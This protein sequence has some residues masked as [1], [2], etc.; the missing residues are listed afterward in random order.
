MTGQNTV[1][2][3][4]ISHSVQVENPPLAAYSAPT[5]P[6]PDIADATILPRLKRG[7]KRSVAVSKC[8]GK[9]RVRWH[10][11]GC[12]HRK[13]FGGKGSADA[14]AA[15]VR[16]DALSR[17]Q[18]LLGLTPQEQDQ[19]IL[20]HDEARRRG[21]S[22]SSLLT[23]L[24]SEEGKPSA[25]PSIDAVLKEMIA[26]KKVV[27]RDKEYLNSLE[28]IIGGFCKGRETLG[29]DQFTYKDVELWMGTKSLRYRT[30]LRSRISTL[31]RFAVKHGYRA[32]NPCDR[33]E[34]ITAAHVPPA[35]LTVG[36][37]ERCMKWFKTR[38]RAMAWFILS[39]F[40]GLR[41]EEASQTPWSAINFKEG[42]IAISPQTTKVRQRRIVYPKK[43]AMDWLKLA[44][45]RKAELPLTEK[46]LTVEQRELRAVLGW[47]KWKQDVTRHSAA[48]YWLADCRAAAHVADA[49]GT[50]E[51]ILQK[52][53]KALVTKS[54]ALKY[55]SI[56]P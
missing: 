15:K 41:P 18:K 1:S 42:W 16:G 27:K 45:R 11:S 51:K 13:F 32:D 28:Q 2:G 54:D 37:A 17:H 3:N 19:L 39:A 52:H 10:E 50:S 48:S 5:Q 20:V 46:Q 22:L 25:S 44:K 55:W 8:A 26:L 7:R 35:V 34:S 30:T 6:Q 21:V 43:M 56:R 14:F 31:F 24:A 47:E 4:G 29:I 12:V 49:L 53:Y 9:W 36:E 33:L 23:L 38:P 40:A